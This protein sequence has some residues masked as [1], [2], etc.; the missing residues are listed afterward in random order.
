MSGQTDRAENQP[1]QDEITPG[2]INRFGSWGT[3][4][5][6]AAGAAGIGFSLSVFFL[7]LHGA[8]GNAGADGLELRAALEKIFVFFWPSAVLLTG[9]RTLQGGVALF[10]LSASL[11]AVYYVFVSLAAYVIH[12]KLSAK[13]EFLNALIR[14]SNTATPAVVRVAAFRGYLTPRILQRFSTK[15]STL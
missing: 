9:T 11:N 3:P 13:L 15:R 12:S 4:E 8:V 7:Y 14:P 2:E 1:A 10:L 6:I 5:R